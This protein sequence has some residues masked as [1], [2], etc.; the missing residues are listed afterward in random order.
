MNKQN[1]YLTLGSTYW[2]QNVF[3][4]V[5]VALTIERN[6]VHSSIAQCG[7]LVTTYQ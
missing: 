5:I 6:K 2:S 7:Q 1:I 3:V 4:E